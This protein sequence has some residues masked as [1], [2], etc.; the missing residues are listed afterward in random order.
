MHVGGKFLQN[1]PL[2]LV[3]HS[4]HF[5]N[6]EKIKPSDFAVLFLS[7]FSNI[8]CVCSKV[9]LSIIGSQKFSISFL[10]ISYI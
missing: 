2:S 3:P 8:N 6:P 9:L 7:F 10:T 4:G 1:L 5:S